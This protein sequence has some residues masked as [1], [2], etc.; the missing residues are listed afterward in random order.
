MD[1]QIIIV[2]EDIAVTY[3]NVPDYILKTINILL[4]AVQGNA[5]QKE[6]ER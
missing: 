2:N 5:E 4:N 6:K 1:N 3:E